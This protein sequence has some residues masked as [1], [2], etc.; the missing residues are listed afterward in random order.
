V[1]HDKFYQAQWSDEEIT[2]DYGKL[3]R[4]RNPYAWGR[5]LVMISGIYGYGTWGGVRL[6]SDPDFL[7]RCA[8]LDVFEFECLFMVQV[9]QGEPEFVTALDVRPLPL[10][11]A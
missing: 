7:K 8:G 9:H 2:I 6:L 11:G 4:V 10:S 1:L 3:V 5:T